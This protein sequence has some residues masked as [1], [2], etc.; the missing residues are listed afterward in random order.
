MSGTMLDY[1]VVVSYVVFIEIKG[2]FIWDKANG[3]MTIC[4]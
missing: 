2:Y 1:P 4:D 3:T